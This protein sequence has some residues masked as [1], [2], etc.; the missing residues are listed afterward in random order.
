MRVSRE[1]LPRAIN[2]YVQGDPSVP[3]K[4][5]PDG[6]PLQVFQPKATVKGTGVAKELEG[7]DTYYA[8]NCP[9]TKINQPRD[10]FKVNKNS[11]NAPFIPQSLGS[12]PEDH[13]E[14]ASGEC[15]VRS[16]SNSMSL[17]NSFEETR[18]VVNMIKSKATKS[19]KNMFD[20]N[21]SMQKCLQSSTPTQLANLSKEVEKLSLIQNNFKSLQTAN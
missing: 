18:S 6:Q 20:K 12:A 11:V 4:R 15:S 2:N 8:L 1:Q 10:L 5:G 7:H 9:S 19:M 14:P 3:V 13:S 16:V 17:K 21:T